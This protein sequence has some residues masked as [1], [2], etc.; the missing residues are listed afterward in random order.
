MYHQGWSGLIPGGL[1]WRDE[2]T[3][4]KINVVVI[5]KFRLIHQRVIT[6]LLTRLSTRLNLS[7]ENIGNI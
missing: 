2:V 3:R 1:T 4:C 7:W 5:G 6:F